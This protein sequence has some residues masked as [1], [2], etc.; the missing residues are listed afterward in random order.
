MSL[1]LERHRR[2]R[3]GRSAT[4][5]STTTATASP[6]ATTASASPPPRARSS[7]AAPIRALGLLPLDGTPPVGGG[8]DGHGRRRPEDDRLRERDRRPG[9]RG[10][11]PA[12]GQGRPHPRVGAG[13]QPRL[14]ALLRRR[15]R[16]SPATPAPRSPACPSDGMA[17]GMHVFSGLPSGRYHL[18]IDADAPAT[19]AASSSSS[20]AVASVMPCA[21]PP[22]QVRRRVG[23]HALTEPS[24]RGGTL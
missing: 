2:D 15:R 10:R 22:R 19:R 1:T 24:R 18:V 3:C 7:P 23:G 12:A 9:R 4:T 5:A 21:T 11:L 14:R 6:T 13:R 17:T 20:P 8:A 16:S